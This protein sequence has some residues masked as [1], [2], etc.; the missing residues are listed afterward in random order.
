MKNN[1]TICVARASNSKIDCEHDLVC[2]L[3]PRCEAL[4]KCRSGFPI[5]TLV[6]SRDL[7]SL[8]AV[9]SQIRHFTVI[10]FTDANMYTTPMTQRNC[11]KATVP[12]RRV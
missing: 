1:T 11:F 8:R 9:F 12:D 6:N 5:A 2:C 10:A 7:S 4:R 3:L